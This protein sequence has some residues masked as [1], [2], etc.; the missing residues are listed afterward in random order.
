MLLIG[1]KVVTI[2]VRSADN[3]VTSFTS[4][5]VRILVLLLTISSIALYHCSVAGSENERIFSL[6]NKWFISLFL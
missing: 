5:F 2:E 6:E 1:T 4:E 3:L